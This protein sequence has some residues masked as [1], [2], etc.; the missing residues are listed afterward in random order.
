MLLKVAGVVLLLVIWSGSVLV[1]PSWTVP[2]SR[3]M[4][5]RVRGDGVAL[6]R[7]LMKSRAVLASEVISS[8]LMRVVLV[9]SAVG[10]GVKVTMRMQLDEG[11]RVVQLLWMVKSEVVWSLVMWMGMVPVLARVRVWGC[12]ALPTWVVAK[13]REFAEAV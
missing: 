8:A 1:A 13:V 5:E 10:C 2:K 12:A 11:R 7:R 3:A 9:G 4:G 6:P